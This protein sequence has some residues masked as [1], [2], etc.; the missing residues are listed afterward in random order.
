MRPCTRR[1]T[2]TLI[3]LLLLDLALTAAYLN[4]AHRVVDAE[5]PAG[6]AGPYDI[7]VVFFADFNRQ[8][9]LGPISRRRIN[10]AATLFNTG[11]VPKLLTIGGRRRHPDRYGAVLMA[12][13]LQQSGIPGSA[14]I[15]DRVSFD[16]VS[17]WQ[18]T[19]KLLQTHHWLRPLLISDPLH[20]A[21]I[22]VI[23]SGPIPITL[24]PTRSI[25]TLLRE[26]PARAWINVHREWLAWLVMTALPSSLQQSLLQCWRDFWNPDG[27]TAPAFHQ[28][29]L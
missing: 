3:L 27:S 22:Q 19:I 8:G 13:Q 25:P 11:T 16:T 15:A 23:A 4:W 5:R 29:S 28:K 2:Q 10:H 1:T 9:E 21:R 7:G 26:Q 12:E 14:L 18:Q 17:N 20:L 6:L 24:S